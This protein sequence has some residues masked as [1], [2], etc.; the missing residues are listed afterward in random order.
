LNI[1]PKFADFKGRKTDA[2]ENED[3]AKVGMKNSGRE[4]NGQIEEANAKNDGMDENASHI[5]R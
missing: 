4:Q 2:L 5:Q 3:E 1:Q